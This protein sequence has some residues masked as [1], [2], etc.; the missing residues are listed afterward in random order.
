[1]EP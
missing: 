1:M